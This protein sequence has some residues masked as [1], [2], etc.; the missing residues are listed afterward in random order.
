MAVKSMQTQKEEEPVAREDG[1]LL[2]TVN[3]NKVTGLP[4]ADR[5]SHSDPYVTCQI[6][7][8]KGTRAR[9]QVVRDTEDHVFKEE[10]VVADWR[11]GDVLVFC[12]YDHNQVGR[13]DLLAT[14]QVPSS[15]IFPDGL[16]ESVQLKNVWTAAGQGM[17]QALTKAN[18]AATPV[19]T[20]RIAVQLPVVSGQERKPGY[21]ELSMPDIK[22]SLQAVCDHLEDFEK[23]MVPVSHIGNFWMSSRDSGSQTA[24]SGRTQGSAVG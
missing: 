1:G 19:M 9:T 20:V 8:K 23:A 6:L 5:S 3:I 22:P 21:E 15:K 11:R 14:V 4:R 12:V 2:V 24:R 17:D 13:D 16:D 10:L 18:L 7:G